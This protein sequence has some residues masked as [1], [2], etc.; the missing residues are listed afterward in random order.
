ME[1]FKRDT[2]VIKHKS[3]ED[4]FISKVKGV[5]TSREETTCIKSPWVW[6]VIMYP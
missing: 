5:S 3:V 6:E 4:E 1:A 2:K